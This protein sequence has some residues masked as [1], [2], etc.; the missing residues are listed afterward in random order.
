ML[1]RCGAPRGPITISRHPPR[2]TH[3]ICIGDVFVFLCFDGLA[4]R[5]AARQVTLEEAYVCC[6]R[7]E[8]VSVLKA[9]ADLL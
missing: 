8:V 3:H 2:C 9:Y 5:G 7:P 4:R 1:P 6:V